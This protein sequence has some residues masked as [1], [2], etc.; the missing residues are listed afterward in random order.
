MRMLYGYCLYWVEIVLHHYCLLVNISNIRMQMETANLV[1][2]DILSGYHVVFLCPM[3]G[4]KDKSAE[5]VTLRLRAIGLTYVLLQ[6]CQIDVTRIYL[7]K[8][9]IAKNSK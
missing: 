7:D 9:L 4:R 8:L 1:Y 2:C 6:I 5:F 3:F